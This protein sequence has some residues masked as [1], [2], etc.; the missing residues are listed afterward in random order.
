MRLHC[1]I[2]FG[3]LPVPR[4]AKPATAFGEGQPSVLQVSL[5]PKPWKSKL[6]TPLRRRLN[7]EVDNCTLLLNTS[8]GNIGASVALY[9]GKTICSAP[10]KVKS[11]R[12]TVLWWDNGNINKV[13][14]P[15]QKRKVTFRRNISNRLCDA[16][17]EFDDELTM[18]SLWKR[19]WDLTIFLLEC[20][21]ILHG[22]DCGTLLVKCEM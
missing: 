6:Q 9:N 14:I 11:H 18:T 22:V 21:I 2:Y 3:P 1:G 7:A 8:G 4:T 5:H 10:S 19:R 20:Y 12:W 15:K 16:G 13:K 17:Y